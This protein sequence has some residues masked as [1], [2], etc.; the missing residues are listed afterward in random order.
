[1]IYLDNAATTKPCRE[2][3]EAML[4]AAE[5]FGNPSS[6]H[7]LGLRSEKLIT[8]AK[9]KLAKKLGG[10]RKNIYFTSGGT[11]ANNLALFGTAY[12]KQKLGRR[13][14]TSEIEHPS[15]LE[16]ARKLEREGFDVVFADVDRDGRVNVGQIKEK[17]TEDTILVSIMHV[18]NETGVIQPVEEIAKA[19][20]ALSP[21][22]AVHTD[23]VQSFGKIPVNINRLGVDMVS[24]SAHKIHGF[25]GCGA[26]YVNNTRLTPVLYGGEQQ[27]ELR[28]GTENVGGILAF[29]AAAERCGCD[30]AQMRHKRSLMAELLKEKLDDIEINGSDEFNSGSVLNVSFPGIKAEILLHSLERHEIYLSTGSACSSHKPQ[31]SHV[32]SAMGVTPRSIAGAVRISFSEFTTDEELITA[33]ERIAEEVKTIRRYM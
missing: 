27:N 28:P 16:A 5:E 14:I 13:I 3:A 33:A 18:N 25:K 22:C 21:K 32:L 31:P 23:C 29:G 4:E 1:M 7:G 26:L 2:A 20:H 12:A 9:E 11:E 8:A 10:D 24:V 15:V 30:A 6:L 17:L 19:A